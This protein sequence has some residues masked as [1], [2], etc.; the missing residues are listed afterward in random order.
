MSR[1]VIEGS[2]NLKNLRAYQMYIEYMTLKGISEETLKSYR[3]DILQ[4]FRYI[5]VYQNNKIYNEIE[6]EDVED[7]LRFCKLHG[8]KED[9]I[10]R[11]CASISSFYIYLK[12]NKLVISSPTEFIDRPIKKM[13][14][15]KKIFLT[16]KQV[17]DLKMNL[18]K[19]NN[20]VAECY[21][22]FSINTACRRGAVQ[23]LKWENVDFEE[24]EA[25]TIEKGPKEVT[26]F[27]SE[28][29]RDKLIELK[30]FY[31]ENNIKSEFV[32]LSKYHGKYKKCGKSALSGWVRK[33]GE[34]INVK[35]LTP[36]ALRR[37]SATIMKLSG[38][39]LEDI[40]KLLN[41]SGTEVTNKHYIQIDKR[42][43][44]EDKD[45]FDI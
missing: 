11:R 2:Y 37:S 24:R 4:W 27:F 3:Y 44:K 25:T 29:V 28:A 39:P 7:F 5:N 8:N 15:R 9:R 10:K 21:I 14:A 35:G 41:H 19:F 26:L 33:A 36:H 31:E 22:L 1:V 23:K 40:S 30:K 32:F 42:K 20:I 13:N 45:K 43:L 38:M 34:M 6:M 18:D 12:R 17:K 16:E